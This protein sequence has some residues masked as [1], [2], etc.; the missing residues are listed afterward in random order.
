MAVLDGLEVVLE[1][2]SSQQTITEFDT[3]D[4]HEWT[5]VR[6]VTKCLEVHEGQHFS[7]KIRAL[8][9]FNWHA[10]NCL[11]KCYL[12]LPLGWCALCC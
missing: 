1:D 8:P 9:S 4:S 5:T 12:G 11:G 10:G 3:K 6:N 7:I 2:T